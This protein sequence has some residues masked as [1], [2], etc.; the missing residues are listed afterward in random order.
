MGKV[1]HF[2]SV[3]PDRVPM[4]TERA[5]LGALEHDTQLVMRG[6]SRISKGL[7]V[8]SVSPPQDRSPLST[9]SQKLGAPGPIPHGLPASRMMFQRRVPYS[10]FGWPKLV[11]VS[12][13]L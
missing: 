7:V 6:P 10:S 4:E 2:L 5:G 8:A 9:R 1:S 12:M 11:G 3:P 13:W